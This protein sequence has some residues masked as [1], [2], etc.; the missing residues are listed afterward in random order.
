[1]RNEP[2]QEALNK[3]HKMNIEM[4]L[5]REKLVIAEGAMRTIVGFEPFNCLEPRRLSE[6]LFEMEE[7]SVSN[8]NDGGVMSAW[9]D[10]IEE[11]L[12]EIKKLRQELNRLKEENEKMREMLRQ[13]KPWIDESYIFEDRNILN[14]KNWLKQYNELMSGENER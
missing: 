9:S 2:T 6:A 14:K 4:K 10:T 12:N 7:L 13:A 1:M 3:L 5:L 8:V 11:Q